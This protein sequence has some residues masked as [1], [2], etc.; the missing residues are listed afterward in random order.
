MRRITWWL[1]AAL[2][3]ALV[4]GSCG[5]VL[6]QKVNEEGKIERVRLATGTKWSTLDKSGAKE[7]DKS[8]LLKKEITF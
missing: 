2:A 3:A 6:T 7:D 5:G 4:A 1:G 8:L